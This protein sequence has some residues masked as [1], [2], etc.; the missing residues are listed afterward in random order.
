M[1][2]IRFFHFPVPCC[3]VSHNDCTQIREL[4]EGLKAVDFLDLIAQPGSGAHP[5]VPEIIIYPEI[6]ILTLS[7]ASKL[8]SG[9]AALTS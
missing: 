3:F 8:P 2:C 1:V 9:F 4:A 6:V 7:M 5:H